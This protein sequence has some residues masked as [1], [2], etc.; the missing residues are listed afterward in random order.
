MIAAA[1]LEGRE[2]AG[3]TVIDAVTEAEDGAK[4][5]SRARNAYLSVL[6]GAF[7]V[8]N[9]VP[10]LAYL[11]TLWAIHITGDS[12]QHSLWTWFTWMGANATMAAWLYETNGQRLSRAA[13][14]NACNAVMCVM[15]VVLIVWHRP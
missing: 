13:V 1:T 15:T 14:V 6:T 2:V 10:I 11:P 7:T 4:R 9:S 8:F 12:S 5:P 3:S